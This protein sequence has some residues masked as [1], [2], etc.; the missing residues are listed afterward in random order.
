MRDPRKVW[1]AQD[2]EAGL[3]VERVYGSGRADAANKPNRFCL[4]TE[5]AI[6]VRFDYFDHKRYKW[7]S[8]STSKFLSTEIK[9]DNLDILT[10][11]ILDVNEDILMES[12]RRMFTT[13]RI[14][15]L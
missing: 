11:V 12:K 3:P 7:R 2:P 14:F 15:Y 6:A 13:R 9:H 4:E 5:K 1:E 8:G 10:H